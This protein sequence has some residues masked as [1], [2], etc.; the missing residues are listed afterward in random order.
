MVVLWGLTPV[1]KVG[2]YIFLLWEYRIFVEDELDDLNGEAEHEFQRTSRG[3]HQQIGREQ[4]L[5]YNIKGMGT[6]L[7]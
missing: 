5:W 2:F 7:F 1:K 6:C 3:Q 4:A